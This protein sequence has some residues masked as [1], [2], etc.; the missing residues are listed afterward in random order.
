MY[1]N[2]KIGVFIS[3]L[4]G[5]YQK[6][7]C[8]GI[9]DKALEYG[10]LT[11]IFA[12]MDGE[13][14][15]EYDR[16]E[17]SILN[18]PN[19]DQLSG[20]I[21]ASD[22]YPQHELR[23]KI[24]QTLK[25]KCTCPIIDITAEKSDFPSVALENN[26]TTYTLTKHLIE[27]HQYKRICYLGCSVETLY[28]DIREENYVKAMTDAGL[29]IGTKDIFHASYSQDSMACA[30]SFFINDDQKPDAI[31][32][33]NDRMALLFMLKAMELGYEIPE[34][35]A[36]TGCDNTEDGK[37]IMPTLTTVSFPAYELG[38]SA[39]DSLIKVIRNEEVPNKKI[40]NA[41]IILGN[42]CGC[43]VNSHKNSIFYI[44]SLVRRI[45]SVESS[46]LSSMRM[47]AAVQNIVDIDDGMD[48]LESYVQNIEHCKEFYL[49]L[50]SGWDSV[51]RHILELTASDDEYNS[52]PDE[53]LLKLAFRDGK[54]LPE[55]SFS[56]N[57][58]LPEYLYSDSDSAYHYMPLYYG[59]KE[60]GYIAISYEANKID[61][62]FRFV[63]WF[64]NINQMLEKLCE[65]KKTSMLV[66]HLEDIYMKDALTGLYNKHGYLHKEEEL[67]ES[68]IANESTITAFLFDLDGLKY[69]NDN[70]GHTEGDFAIQV[71]GH[72]LSSVIRSNDIC[73]RYSGD[74][75]YLLTEDYTKKDADDLIIRVQ[76]YLANYNKLSN[77]DYIINASGGY[78]Q[79]K[80]SASFHKDQLKELFKLA[81]TNM[82]LQ[83]HEHHKTKDLK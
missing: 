60:F 70:F 42:S 12:S 4:M 65:I 66:T 7:V 3:H 20:V 74:E 27:V 21:F 35:F 58:M 64:M 14:L 72:A 79:A 80:A 57:T 83:K 43:K 39:T 8:Q 50:Y 71:I 69:I 9:V 5:D 47:S 77:K 61:S 25:E 38:N 52:Q 15:G 59:D 41:E 34:D 6:N 23:D 32:C 17:E 67:V 54:R 28:S 29:E 22:T 18:I 33:Y 16:G 81:D 62:R 68:A 24:Y 45:N 78:A 40:I 13:N 19:Y 56:K 36:I 63:Q 55:C 46:I 48:L 10:Y 51:S 82:Y 31:V 37:N 53:M 2:K 75:F 44:Q 30:L 26:T 11:E 73:A 49:C 76:K 1:H